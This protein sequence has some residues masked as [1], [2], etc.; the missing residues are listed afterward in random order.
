MG[1]ELRAVILAET[2]A[3]GGSKKRPAGID[4]LLRATGQTQKER[5]FSVFP[6]AMADDGEFI[7][8]TDN[9]EKLPWLLLDLRSR[10]QPFS[11]RIGVGIGEVSGPVAAPV[12]KWK[13]AAV[14]FARQALA[15]LK[16]ARAGSALT[17]FGSENTD[18]DQT[19]NLI[20]A[21]NDTVVRKMSSRQWKA[22]AG[23]MERSHADEA[24][25]APGAGISAAMRKLKTDYYG[26][27]AAAAYGAEQLIGERFLG[28][29]GKARK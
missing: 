27:L 7:T 18:F 29:D 3:P 22:V 14:R 11:L 24:G 15:G 25:G 10:M 16:K 13:G 9:L 5:E 19:A 2:I 17:A 4:E 12:N 28:T 6:Y 8:V 20:Y 23:R 1:R 21:L 26:Q